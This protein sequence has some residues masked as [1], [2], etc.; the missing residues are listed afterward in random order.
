MGHVSPSLPVPGTPQHL[1]AI[2]HHVSH[3]DAAATCLDH[4]RSESIE[5]S[6]VEFRKIKLGFVVTSDAWS[7]ALKRHR[8]DVSPG[9]VQGLLARAIEIHHSNEIVTVGDEKI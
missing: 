9:I 5:K 4:A 6:L 7:G 1:P 8:T 3:V 2:K